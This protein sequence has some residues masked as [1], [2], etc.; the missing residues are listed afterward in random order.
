MPSAM[1]G[2]IIKLDKSGHAEVL[3]RAGVVLK[4]EQPV[5]DFKVGDQVLASIN[6]SKR[7][8]KRLFTEEPPEEIPRPEPEKEIFQFAGSNMDEVE[9]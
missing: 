7:N 6:F 5:T 9:N 3:L 8:I 4:T 2:T 1:K